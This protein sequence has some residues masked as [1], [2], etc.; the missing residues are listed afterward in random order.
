MLVICI[1]PGHNHSGPDAGAEGNGLREQDL[2][3]EIAKHLKF[4]LIANGFQVVMTRDD[5]LVKGPHQTEKQSLQSRCTIA[6]K[7]GADLFLSIHINAGGGT[8]S[9]VY[10]LPGGKA[11]KVAAVLLPY[12]CQAGSWPNRGVKANKRFYVLV[13]THMP[14][15]LTENGFIDHPQDVQKL[16]NPLFRK[17]LA[18]AH[19]QGICAYYG[20]IF[21]D[22]ANGTES[23]LL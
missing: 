19:A 21:R 7:A 23:E 22:P 11:E 10:V 2:T 12:L 17:R 3:L 15:L 1:D 5:E 8:G 4:L 18:R 16:R 20:I 9:E 13:N 14:A 6:N